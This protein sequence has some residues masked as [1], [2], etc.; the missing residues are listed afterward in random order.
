M[1]RYASAR[2]M[3]EGFRAA[4]DELR[5]YESAV[6]VMRAREGLRAQCYD[7]VGRGSGPRDVMAAT[8]ARL[9]YE[10]SM[11]PAIDADRAL[12]ADARTV[13][14]GVDG[15]GGISAVCGP[16]AAMVLELRYLDLLP[17]DAVGRAVCES[18]R[19]AQR[20]AAAALDAVDA[21]GVRRV[22]DGVGIAC[23]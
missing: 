23:E 9:D 22:V 14:H 18:P 4:A 2:D 5:R 3:F 10:T 7:A 17:W 13:L 11:R 6:R 19:T 15:R 21:Y 1:E 20:R 16:V 12:V 8:D